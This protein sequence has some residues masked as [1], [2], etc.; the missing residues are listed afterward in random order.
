[1]ENNNI[2]A[3]RTNCREGSNKELLYID[4]NLRVAIRYKRNYSLYEWLET[5]ISVR[6]TVVPV[7]V[8]LP[9]QLAWGRYH[10]LF[11]V[12]QHPAQRI[13]SVGIISILDRFR[14]NLVHTTGVIIYLDLIYN[15]RL[16]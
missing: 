1:V 16:L 11:R 15:V 8:K 7:P 9:K 4:S 10:V 5:Y 12:F 14:I 13:I 2:A 3:E 6:Q